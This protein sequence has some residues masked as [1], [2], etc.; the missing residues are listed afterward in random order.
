MKQNLWR[1]MFAP[2]SSDAALAKVRF[3]LSRSNVMSDALQG[4]LHAQWLQF[5][6]LARIASSD[7][8]RDGYI[9]SAS[10]LANLAG[11][12]FKPEEEQHNGLS[13]PRV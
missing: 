9:Q 11:V 12:L 6:H 10:V 5:H 3:E 7:A 8:E 1:E 4:Y 13:L 2:E